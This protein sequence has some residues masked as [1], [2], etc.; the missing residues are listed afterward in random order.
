VSSIPRPWVNDLD[1]YV[2]G[3]PATNELG[4]LASNESPL[5]ASP[6]V[7]EAIAKALSEIHRYP[8]PLA[9]E[10]RDRLAR[11]L[12]VDAAQI[13]VG[14]G[15]DELIY[16]LVMAFG[17][18]GSKVV[19]A[20]P[21]YR[22]HEVVSQALGASLCRIP[23]RD[24]RHD[25]DAMFSE[26]ADLCFICNPHNPTGT[27]VSGKAIARAIAG[28]DTNLVVVDEAYVDFAR[29]PGALTALPLVNSDR[30]VVLRTFSKIHSL[31]GLRIGYLV[32]P[33][34]VVEVL[35]K[36]RAPFSVNA[37]AQVAAVAALDDEAHAAKVRAYVVKT[38]EELRTTFQEFGFETVPSETNFIL[39]LCPAEEQL[40]YQLAHRGI[41]VRPGRTLGIPGSVRVTVPPPGG[42]KL[43]RQAL[44]STSGEDR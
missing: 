4:R 1:P 37:L 18:P 27:T 30:V 8:D 16:L 10:L 24:R 7:G 42:L 39:V 15:S 22:I 17:P 43:L 9:D 38:R 31:A 23:L 3:A 40:V 21:P 25:L 36:I 33:A 14:N 19:V 44:A 35:R 5:G 32:G 28:A 6:R 11:K 2:V 41:S 13:L 26:P 12:G 20:D 34:E 29:D